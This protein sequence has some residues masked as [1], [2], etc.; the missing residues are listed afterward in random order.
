MKPQLLYNFNHFPHKI[1]EMEVNPIAVMLVYM[2]SKGDRLLFRYP[3]ENGYKDKTPLQGLPLAAS[4]PVLNNPPLVDVAMSSSST[5]LVSQISSETCRKRN[6][7]AINSSD[8]LLQTVPPP[9]VAPTTV[10]GVCN[11][12]MC[13]TVPK[14]QLEGF[15]DEVLSTLFAVKQQLCNQKL[16]LK[17]NDVRFVSHPTL[18][19]RTEQRSSAGSS[20]IASTNVSTTSTNMPLAG[21]GQGVP[22]G[23]TTTSVLI[24]PQPKSQPQQMLINIVF[25]L[26][27]QASYSIVKCYYELSKRLGLA[28]RVEEQRTG[29]CTEETMLM[30]RT[31]DELSSQQQPL[32]RTFDAIAERSTLAQ[33]LK[34][35]YHDLCTTGL[36]NT[37][38]NQY[39]TVSFC[40]PQKAH[41]LH[42]KGSMVDPE[43][44]DRCLRS[45]K[46]YHGMLLVDYAE[47]L[48]C[49]PPR[50]ARMLLQLVE[51]YTP[52]MSLQML[53]SEADM[54]IEHVYKMVSHLVYWG[55]ATIIYPLCETNVYVIAPDAPL[56]TKSHLVEKFSARFAGMS[57][58]DAISHFSLPTS[59]GHLT[60]PLQQSARQG[61]LAQMVVWMLQHHLLMQLHTYV[62]FMPSDFDDFY[63]GVSTM[64]VAGS[65]CSGC[66][67]AENEH[68]SSLMD[69]QEGTNTISSMGVGNVGEL[70]ISPLSRSINVSDDE[71]N[72][73]SL[74][75]CAS[76]PLP[77]PHTSHRSITDDRYSGGCSTASDNIVAQPSSSHKSNFS[78]TASISTE[79]CE[80]IASIEDEE[81]IK[82]LL[83]VF[84]E[85]DRAAIRRIPASSNVDDL[86]LLV[87][88]YQA[89]YFKS[90]HHLEEIMY[91]QSLRPAELLQLLDKFRDVLIIYE[92]ED[93]AIASMY[94]NK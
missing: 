77:V 19:P 42:K 12:A 72:V 87:K 89:G 91:F 68:K 16:E 53:A 3:Y 26:H 74:L 4:A 67:D 2:D 85:A 22:G 17:V 14:G 24:L 23:S 6:P 62:Q 90:E 47:L 39:L 11:S 70:M 57:L 40:L 34:S 43:A 15:T 41:Q 33:A 37:T 92:T 64:N 93:P 60:T 28:L 44:I 45:L 32:E 58:F 51:I 36:L 54:S 65:E 73:G 86:S 83:S 25:A 49:V 69:L 78:M 52:L 71:L 13:T 84:N 75:S 27:A 79:N 5:S 76:Q 10:F 29:Y 82:E 46:P 8:E 18:I 55:K 48:D 7:Y 81:K 1:R 61:M 20:G 94:N 56:H 9:N 59:I 21:S 88:L 31:H 66:S 63:G 30:A 80:S 50:A 35:I 38:L